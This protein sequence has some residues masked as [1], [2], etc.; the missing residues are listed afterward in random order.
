MYFRRLRLK[1]LVLWNSVW[2]KIEIRERRRASKE[3]ERDWLSPRKKSLIFRQKL[4]PYFPGLLYIF[5]GEAAIFFV[6]QIRRKRKTFFPRIANFDRHLF[7]PFFPSR[8]TA[9]VEVKFF[10]FCRVRLACVIFQM[11]KRESG[12]GF[13]SDKKQTLLLLMPKPLERG[14]QVMKV[15]SCAFWK[16]PFFVRL[17][18][19][20]L[21]WQIKCCQV[22]APCEFCW[23]ASYKYT[24]YSV[25]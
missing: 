23:C 11:G 9:T 3:E 12:R 17:F 7:F 25:I 10:F 18:S 4:F 21:F 15:D 19:R 1:K 24:L 13:F 5:G 6:S 16:S 2:E 14:V 22:I 20:T 8:E